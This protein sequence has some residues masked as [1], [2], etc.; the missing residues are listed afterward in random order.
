VTIETKVG[1]SEGR[2]EEVHSTASVR[3]NVPLKMFESFHKAFGCIKKSPMN[4][5]ET[6]RVW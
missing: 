3:V 1:P 6:C 5:A 2:E 4:L